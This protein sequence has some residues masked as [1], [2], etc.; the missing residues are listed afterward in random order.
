[1]PQSILR[2]TLHSMLLQHNR[3]GEILVFP[4]WPAGW[5]TSFK[6]HAPGGVVVSARCINDTVQ[7]LVVTPASALARVRVVGCKTDD[8]V[9]ADT[10]SLFGVDAHGGERVNIEVPASDTEQ[11][12]L[13]LTRTEEHRR[14]GRAVQLKLTGR[15]LIRQPLDFA[16]APSSTH[17]TTRLLPKLTVLG[18]AVIDGGV[19]IDGW[20]RE[21]SRSW[22]F[23]APVPESASIANTSIITQMW[24]GDQRVPPARTPVLHY[25][26]TGVVNATTG[27]TQSII[28]SSNVSKLITNQ[29]KDLATVR[30]F[31]YR[32]SSTCR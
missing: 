27:M 6:L 25:C 8:D 29:L 5:E 16:L 10:E 3:K 13:A 9:D 2:Q 11:L 18:P 20:T 19:D 1:M 4:A 32:E 12:T 21:S 30:L 26:S 23:S 28:V 7:D 31:M 22:L 15:Y 14:A 17:L 24:A